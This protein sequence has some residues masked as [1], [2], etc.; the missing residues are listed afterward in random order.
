MT[1][2]PI[3]SV[4]APA[5]GAP[6]DLDLTNWDPWTPEQ[7][8]Q[9]LAGIDVP[10][11]VCGGWA[12]ELFH[13]DAG[14][15][16]LR[17]HEDLEFGICRPDFPVVRAALLAGGGLAQYSAGGGTLWP[18]PADEL[19]PPQITQVWTATAADDVF[20]TDLFLDPG[21]HR[22]WVCKRDDRLVRPLA[23]TIARS[24]SGVPYQRA[25]VV[26]LMKA[27]HARGKD[28]AD[29]TATLPL[30][31]AAQR[32]WLAGALRLIHPGHPWIERVA[33]V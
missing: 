2:G 21:S 20:R 15:G 23:D 28:V 31:S 6:A 10:W 11:W 33:P 5:A 16:P 9:R 25:D 7:L 1:D 12:L 18:L 26:L 29:F 30:L 17:G 22:Q 19:P 8:A 32:D 4:P 27:K 3:E 24:A 13:R 14:T